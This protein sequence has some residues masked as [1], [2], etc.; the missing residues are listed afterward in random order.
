MKKLIKWF[1]IGIIGLAAISVI[2]DNGSSSTS[3]TSDSSKT[4]AKKIPKEGKTQIKT[5]ANKDTKK[6]TNEEPQKPYWKHAWGN[7]W[8][9]VKLYYGSG[10]KKMY[11]GKVVGIKSD[12]KDPYTGQ[13]YDAV[14]VKYPNGKIEP[15][16]RDAIVNG[17]WYV[18]SDDPA[19]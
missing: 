13:E 2:M 5:V 6:A 14:F 8:V 4:E 12:F 3:T 1:F 9:G 10:S 19:L 18:R 7:I 11:V 17:E 15:K 16:R